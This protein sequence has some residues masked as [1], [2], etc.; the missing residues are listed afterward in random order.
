MSV[1]AGP[2]IPTK[3]ICLVADAQNSKIVN[4]NDLETLT[5]IV[6]SKNDLPTPANPIV[7]DNDST[8]GRCF[9]FTNNNYMIQG[10][11]T[12]VIDKYNFSVIWWVKRTTGKNGNY[13]RMWEMET[14]DNPSFGYYFSSD[15][16]LVDQEYIHT[17]VKDYASNSW[18]ATTPVNETTWEN[19][20]TFFQLAITVAQESEYKHYV[21]GKLSG[22]IAT[23]NQDLSSYGNVDQIQ[24]GGG[25]NVGCKMGYFSVYRRALT[26][27]EIFENY[28]AFK[29]RFGL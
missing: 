5:N 23:T 9:G 10:N 6:E 24:I 26:A 21:N 2:K 22:T 18:A 25:G 12:P 16:R 27:A 29:S 20:T 19:S 11:W 15:T 28:N 1:V 3:N 14:T 4:D 7:V 8:A 17:Y 13:S